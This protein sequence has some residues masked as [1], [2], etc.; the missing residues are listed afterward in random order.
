M[1]HEIMQKTNKIEDSQFSESSDETLLKQ[2]AELRDYQALQAL[3]NRYRHSV[4]SFLFRKFGEGQQADE[5]FNDV[6]LTV[7]QKAPDFRS[8]SKVSTWIFGIAYRVCLS[9]SRKE[10][11]HRDH[12]EI[13]VLERM[14]ESVESEGVE[15]LKSAVAQLSEHHRTVVELA[16]FHGFS[17]NEISDIA[18][19][20]VNTVK[21]RL[22]YARKQ[23]KS[24]MQQAIN[25]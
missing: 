10:K 3:Y 11:K 6:M 8:E 19:C 25:P 15:Q 13:D 24:V 1:A 16:Y 22:Y 14:P 23:L 17:L 7:W 20:P 18:D 21:T 12:L 5:I 4:G 9:H 2:I